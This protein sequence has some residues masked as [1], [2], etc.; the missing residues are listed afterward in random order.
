[1]SELPSIEAELAAIGDE[2]LTSFLEKSVEAE[3]AV[4]EPSIVDDVVGETLEV[5]PADALAQKQNISKEDAEKAL[6]TGYNPDKYD[7]ANPESKSVMEY[8]RMGEVLD[9]FE[10]AVSD[11]RKK[12]DVIKHLMDK[13]NKKEELAYQRALTDIETKRSE[14]VAEGDVQRFN[15]LDTEYK[16][17]QNELQQFKSDEVAAPVN[18]VSSMVDDFSKRNGTWYNRENFENSKMMDF[19][20]EYDQFLTNKNPNREVGDNLKDVELEVRKRFPTH[21]SF[22]NVERDRG[23]V[24]SSNED[25]RG[26]TNRSTVRDLSAFQRQVFSEIHKADPTYTVDKY[27]SEVE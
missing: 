13:F 18:D 11:I 25:K 8:N 15:Q 12:D 3:A 23:S 6:K 19:A 16:A 2:D 1:M 21:P 27:L 20:I 7:P 9:K 5:D 10:N 14:A 4:E 17:T 22:K 26:T 24:V